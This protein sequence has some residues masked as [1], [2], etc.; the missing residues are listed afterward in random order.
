[1]PAPIRPRSAVVACE[2]ARGCNYEPIKIPVARGWA[3]AWTAFMRLVL[4]RS[5]YHRRGATAHRG[6]AR[7]ERSRHRQRM[8]E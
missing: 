6:L 8:A 3:A 4:V 1:M 7:G 2:V 5:S